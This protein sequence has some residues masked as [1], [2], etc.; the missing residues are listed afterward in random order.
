M[1][2]IELIK[3][4]IKSNEEHLLHIFYNESLN[5]SE[6]G[7][8]YINT[9][10]INDIQVYF[11]KKHQMDTSSPNYKQVIENKKKDICFI[12]GIENNNEYVLIGIDYNVKGENSSENEGLDTAG[13]NNTEESADVN[14]YYCF[15]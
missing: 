7:A 2:K 3:Y 5:G 10:D 1:D 11:V 15:D 13:E 12:I 14:T 8:L 4:F 9:T 6:Q